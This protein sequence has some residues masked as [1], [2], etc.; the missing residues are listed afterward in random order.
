M[1]LGHFNVT[2]KKQMP[3]IKNIDYVGTQHITYRH[4]YRFLFDGGED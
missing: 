2:N 4:T 3:S 1:Y